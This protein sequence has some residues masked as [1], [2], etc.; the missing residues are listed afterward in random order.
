MN[1]AELDCVQLYSV[2]RVQPYYRSILLCMVALDSF[3][4]A[5]AVVDENEVW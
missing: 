1:F 2:L 4:D 5:E 3:V